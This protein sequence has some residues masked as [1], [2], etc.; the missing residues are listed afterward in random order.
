MAEEDIGTESFGEEGERGPQSPDEIIFQQCKMFALHIQ[1]KRKQLGASFWHLCTGRCS[2]RWGS[3][4][5]SCHCQRCQRWREREDGTRRSQG[6]REKKD[7]K[8][9]EKPKRKVQKV[10]G[11]Q[12]QPRVVPRRKGTKTESLRMP[13]KRADGHALYKS[14]QR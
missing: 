3:L 10:S 9:L 12:S 8:G 13:V 2:G 7:D 14:P 1:R 6:Q 5:C 11:Q 4:S